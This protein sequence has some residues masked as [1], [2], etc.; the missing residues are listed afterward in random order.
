MTHIDNNNYDA[1]WSEW[2]A[3]NGQWTDKVKDPNASPV[4]ESLDSRIELLLVRQRQGIGPNFINAELPDFGFD[5]KSFRQS[6]SLSKKMHNLQI[7]KKRSKR[8]EEILGTPPSPFLSSSDYIKWHKHTRAVDAGLLNPADELDVND[9]DELL[10]SIDASSAD[11]TPVKDEKPNHL[12]RRR[13]TNGGDDD[14]R[15]SLSSLSSGEKLEVNESNNRQQ[16]SMFP[17]EQAQLMARMGIWKPGDGADGFANGDQFPIPASQYHSFQFSGHSDHESQQPHGKQA[18]DYNYNN[19]YQN[20]PTGDN[21]H[22]AYPV[23]ENYLDWYRQNNESRKASLTKLVLDAV[24]AEL[25]EVIKKDICKKM[26]ESMGYKTY[27]NWWNEMETR[28]KE[29]NKERLERQ[30]SSNYNKPIVKSYDVSHTLNRPVVHNQSGWS[31]MGSRPFYDQ[32]G[33]GDSLFERPMGGALGLRSVIPKMPSFRRKRVKQPSPPHDDDL[34]R[35]H[36]DSDDEKKDK[37]ES[38]SYGAIKSSDNVQKNRAAAVIEDPLSSSDDSSDDSTKSSSDESSSAASSGD[39]SDESSDASSS[40]SESSSKSKSTSLSGASSSSKKKVL[41]KKKSKGILS[42]SDESDD[43]RDVDEAKAN[44]DKEPIDSQSKDEELTKVDIEGAEALMALAGLGGFGATAAI[45][46]ATAVPPVNSDTDSA[47]ETDRIEENRK[48]KTVVDAE[49]SYSL[50]P[51]EKEL[52]A[53]ERA[54]EKPARGGK[55]QAAKKPSINDHMYSRA[56]QKAGAK[57]AKAAAPKAKAPPKK[58]ATEANVDLSRFTI[59][60]EWRNA[61]RGTASSTTVPSDI[62]DSIIMSPRRPATPKPTY[63]ARSTVDEMSILYDFLKTGIDSEDVQFLKRS[64]DSLLQEDRQ[65]WLNDTHWV[66]HPATVTV[67]PPKKK[68][69]NDT[70]VHVTGCARSEGYYKMDINEKWAH[71]HVTNVGEAEEL[72]Q[73]ELRA[74]GAVAQ[75]S[76]REARSN[77]RRLLATVDAAWSDLLKFNQLQVYYLLQHLLLIV[78]RTAYLTFRWLLYLQFRKKQLKFARSRIHDWGL[79][80]LEPIAADEMVIEYVGQMIRPITADFREKQYN[81]QGIGSSYLFRVDL[82]TII[83]A[84]RYGNLARFINHSC[85]VS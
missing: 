21:G 18:Y 42:S 46:D 76:N 68:R 14:D 62:I 24:V 5:P 71:S 16:N 72:A 78:L 50:P 48:P 57:A 29:R 40:L 58:K 20:A 44:A 45:A 23:D 73:K 74:R 27:A 67:Q 81:E 64:Y 19:D 61:K 32:H 80:A 11:G 41:K 6:T 12:R 36:G 39:D 63:K 4:R 43:E 37:K 83:D 47:P 51:S 30:L 53:M 13:R 8:R 31:N 38:D 65:F 33:R 66:D 2:G 52:A 28:H 3:A 85:N 25:K 54:Q 26:T 77:Q 69:K 15:M 59:A 1:K 84:T 56:G 9:Y 7:K 55:K 79:F 35:R 60:S 34:D 10:E 82:E 75:Q 22:S 70:R 17:N 49:H